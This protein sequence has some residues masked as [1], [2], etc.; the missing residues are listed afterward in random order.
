MNTA[1]TNT[2]EPRDANARGEP[3]VPD[4][5][6]RT[7]DALGT[8]FNASPMAVAALDGSRRVVLWSRAATRL[9]GWEAA[10]I[11]GRPLPIVPEDAREQYDRLWDTVIH[12][13]GVSNLEVRR[14]TRTG[15]P[16]D[17]VLSM[18]PLA[19]ASGEIAGVLSVYADI[20][21]H[22]RTDRE[23]ARVNRALRTLTASDEALTR[24]TEEVGL[25]QETC[26]II[27][28][29]GY[30][31]SWVGYAESDE[32]KT[33]TP[34]AFAGFED[35]YVE[36]VRI[37]WADTE[38]G[39]GPTGTAI[40]ENRPVL[41][42]DIHHD[43]RFAPWREDALQRGYEASIALPLRDAGRVFGALMI[44]AR[45]P[46]AFVDE[47][48]AL[49]TRLA[50]NLSH[51]ITGLR[52]RH[53]QEAAEARARR[54]D[55][56][57]RT[58]FET[59]TESIL[60]MDARGTV[61]EAN[62]AVATFLGH[63]PAEIIGR[64][65]WEIARTEDPNLLHGLLEALLAGKPVPD[66]VYFALFDSS[67][68][69]RQVMIRARIMGVE[70]QPPV[71]AI[72][73]RDI[74]EERESERVALENERLAAI[75]RASAFIGHELTTPLTNIGLIASAMDRRSEDPKVKERLAK[76]QEQR[77]LA[78]RFLSDLM[79]ISRPI[80]LH[81]A[82]TDLRDVVRSA[83]D[84][85]QVYR[86]NDVA[87]NLSLGEKPVE[88]RV[89]PTR[90]MQVV[91]NLVK[92]ALE[93]TTTGH[94]AVRL[95]G[96]PEVVVITVEDTG[97]GMAPDTLRRIWEPFFTTKPRPQG[98]GLG[99]PLCRSIVSAHHGT[100]EVRS[101]VGQ[102]SVFTVTVPRRP[103]SASA[104]ASGARA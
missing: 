89:D 40:R 56:R 55:L 29:S 22:R 48:V 94:V 61:L 74:T 70:G 52:A 78:A 93:A 64:S 24:E 80:E 73:G 53:A 51:G 23:L 26:R 92:N 44:Y 1:P 77:A 39:R 9:F 76:I 14:Q 18:A 49:L 62:P 3:E 28:D 71:V 84:E 21:R 66:P 34:V 68:R 36:R 91:D 75:G 58:L 81:L 4:E 35:G 95:E 12:G 19:S 99:L 37:T 79:S 82:P 5:L 47:E 54:S 15:E 46:R 97:P 25:L 38:R 8:I 87:L 104:A 41:A 2:E 90:M 45:D 13:E 31:L 42:R 102:G 20:T 63:S 101:A 65:V 27:V 96:R 72:I 83:A 67:G 57:Y 103:R 43:P 50:E 59:A 100:I 88:A 86:Q 60:L 32:A 30:R 17:L 7:L 85:V 6:H 11:L 33:V 10:E 98:N 16:L 69:R